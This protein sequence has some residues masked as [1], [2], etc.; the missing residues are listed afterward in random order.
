MPKNCKKVIKFSTYRKFSCKDVYTM[1]DKKGRG[2]NERRKMTREYQVKRLK[3]YV[4]PEAVYRQALWAVKDVNR[5]REE[6]A[7]A[8]EEIDNIH[9]PDFFNESVGK[10]IYSDITAK[11]ADRLIA[12]TNRIDSIEA[13]M[14]SIPERYRQGM[15]DKL[16]DGGTFDD[17]F[18]PNT[19]KKWQ[20]VFIFNVAKNLGLM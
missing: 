20:Q 7:L 16:I 3:S 8:I 5:L 15:R 6:L 11:K 1:L 9:S 13:A 4:L 18:H 12:L 10:G 2:N 17:S 19:W 14:F